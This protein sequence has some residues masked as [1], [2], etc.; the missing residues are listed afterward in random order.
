M[1]GA[2]AVGRSRRARSGGGSRGVGGVADAGG[3]GVGGHVVGL[4]VIGEGL[5][6][7]L[8]GDGVD[9]CGMLL[10][11][12]SGRYLGSL[13]VGRQTYWQGRWWCTR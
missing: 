7:E 10:A 6:A 12:D 1:S 5:G 3:E 4:A 11:I 13:I 8:V 9:L 2:S